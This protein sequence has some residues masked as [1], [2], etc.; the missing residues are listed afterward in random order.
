M[1]HASKTACRE[2][3]YIA[4]MG[5]DEFVVMLPGV[6]PQDVAAKAGQFRQVVKDIARELFNGGVLTASIGIAHFPD[7]GTD[8]EQLLAEADRKMY[9]EK[10]AH[11]RDPASAPEPG[12]KSEW[13]A[14]IQ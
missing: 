14:I 13:A 2:Y 8:A 10:H 5:G 4:R 7:N 12:W 1:R 3:D 6:D 11:R 9:K